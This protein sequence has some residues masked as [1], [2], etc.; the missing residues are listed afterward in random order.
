MTRKQ[1]ETELQ[2]RLAVAQLRFDVDPDRVEQW[3]EL[4]KALHR[5]SRFLQAGEIPSDLQERE[6]MAHTA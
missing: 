6:T 5:Y 1:I 3:S 2:E 4:D